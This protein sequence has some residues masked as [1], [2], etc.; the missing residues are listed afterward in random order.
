MYLSKTHNVSR[1][2]GHFHTRRKLSE[3]VGNCLGKC[4]ENPKLLNLK[5]ANYL[6]ENLGNFGC[7]LEWSFR[8]FGNT[9]WG[10]PLFRKFSKHV[11]AVRP[12]RQ[13]S[14]LFCKFEQGDLKR[15]NIPLFW[16]FDRLFVPVTLWLSSSIR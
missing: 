12:C 14:H 3:W 11:V 7:K 1:I 5:K 13:A 9:S 10:Y 6:T 8:K 4:P 15:V 2:R 16:H